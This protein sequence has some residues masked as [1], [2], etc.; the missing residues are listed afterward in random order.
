M[1]VVLLIHRY[2]GRHHGCYGLNKIYY[3]KI[4]ITVSAALYQEH[5][6]GLKKTRIGGDRTICSMLFS[7]HL[8]D[9]APE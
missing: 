4:E 3:F 6:G 2:H 9:V 1:F 7:L 5:P 8:W